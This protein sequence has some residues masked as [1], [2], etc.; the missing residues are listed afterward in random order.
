MAETA[1]AEPVLQAGAVAVRLGQKPRYLLVR[2]RLH[3]EHWLFPKGHIDGDESLE[4]AAVRELAEEAG[5]AGRVLA[6]LG[7]SGYA[8][9]GKRIEVHYFLVEAT[10]RAGA[11]EPD[12][13]PSWLTYEA[14]IERIVFVDLHRILDAAEAYVRGL[15]RKGKRR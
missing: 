11:G 9:E 15:R 4:E 13:D 6:P 8:F 10:G 14:A 12:R 2:A 3:P 1:R 5:V 7:S